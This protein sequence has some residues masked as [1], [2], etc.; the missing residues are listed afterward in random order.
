MVLLQANLSGTTSFTQPLDGGFMEYLIGT[1][2][3]SNPENLKLDSML[4][5][6]CATFDYNCPSGCTSYVQMYITLRDV[7][8]LTYDIV[9]INF[10]DYISQHNKTICS[11]PYDNY[12][13]ILQPAHTYNVYIL[14]WWQTVLP[15]LGPKTLY[16]NDLNI[17]TEE[18]DEEPEFPEN[19][20]I[21]PPDIVNPENPTNDTTKLLLFVAAGLL[22]VA[23]LF[24][25]GYKEEKK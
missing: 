9:S 5:E 13:N 21:Y 10:S 17:N 11:Q 12:S 7:T 20:P 19:P 25:L 24:L 18:T 6:A 1:I 4:S 14:I 16:I 22:G 15:H 2:S 8:D 3:H 23:A